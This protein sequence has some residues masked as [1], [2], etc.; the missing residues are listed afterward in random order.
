ML[1]DVQREAQNRGYEDGKRGYSN[2]PRSYG[3]KPEYGH[4]IAAYERGWQIGR[5]DYERSINDCS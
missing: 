1:D 4:L 2:S 5:Q 3:Y